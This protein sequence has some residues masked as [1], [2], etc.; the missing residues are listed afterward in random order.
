MLTYFNIFL[1]L[2]RVLEQVNFDEK[3]SHLPEFN[4]ADCQSPSALSL[5][6]S[7]RVFVQ[8]YRRRRVA[9]SKGLNPN[10]FLKLA[11]VTEYFFNQLAT[12]EEGDSD[13]SNASATPQSGAAVVGHK[14]FGPDFS[15]DAFKGLQ[16][17]L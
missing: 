14:F 2:Y 6:S 8:N 13:V 1:N 15:L 4:P 16:N 9:S 10:H 11:S 5:P 17:L 3:F 12:E 7:P